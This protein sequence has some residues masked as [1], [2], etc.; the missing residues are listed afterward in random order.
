MIEVY[1]NVFLIC[2]IVI[3]I[4]LTIFTIIAF[5]ELFKTMKDL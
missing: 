5:I 1:E 4:A 2:G 3:T